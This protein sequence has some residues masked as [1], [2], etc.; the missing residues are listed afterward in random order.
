MYQVI[1]SPFSFNSEE[2]LLKLCASS[3]LHEENLFIPA[4]QTGRGSVIPAPLSIPGELST[5]QHRNFPK[6]TIMES[7][8]F[9]KVKPNEQKHDT[10]WGR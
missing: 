10:S 2:N 3:V 7:H 5:P 4:F 6:C 8:T 1:D 9:K